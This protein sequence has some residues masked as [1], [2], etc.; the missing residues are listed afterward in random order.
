VT[1]IILHQQSGFFLQIALNSLKC[2]NILESRIKSPKTGK[3]HKKEILSLTISWISF[4]ILR[5]PSS[6]F[7][8][9][10]LRPQSKCKGVYFPQVPGVVVKIFQDWSDHKANAKVFISP[11]FQ[12]LLSKYFKTGKLSNIIQ[13][14]KI[15]IY[16]ASIL[17]SG[18]YQH[19]SFE[20]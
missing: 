18:M 16:E 12:V 1:V 11:K 19:V 8:Q 15:K 5:H 4:N 9:R 13:S 14:A 7:Y 17:M 10:F 2:L 6:Y 20:V 3:E